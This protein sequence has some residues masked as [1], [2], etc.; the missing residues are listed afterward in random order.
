[1]GGETQ[2]YYLAWVFAS[3]L[4]CIGLLSFNEML[5]LFGGRCETASSEK[6]SQIQGV[7]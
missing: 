5:V 2:L 4:N 7:M 6:N 1:M 3:S